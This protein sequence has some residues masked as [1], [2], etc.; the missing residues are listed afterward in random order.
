MATNTVAQNQPGGPG[1][2]TIS[3]A[4]R[5][6]YMQIANLTTNCIVR[7]KTFENLLSSLTSSIKSAYSNHKPLLS[8][9]SPSGPS[10]LQGN[11]KSTNNNTTN[12]NG[13]NA[14][15]HLSNIRLEIDPANLF[16][17]DFSMLEVEEDKESLE[18]RRSSGVTMDCFRKTWLN[19]P[20]KSSSSKSVKSLEN[21]TSGDN[22]NSVLAPIPGIP[23]FP[24]LGIAVGGNGGAGAASAKRWRRCAR[25]AAVMEDVISP[26]PA[27][28]WLVMQ[29][30]RCFCGGYWDTLVGGEMVA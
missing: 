25:C 30:R 11:E 10:R 13:G 18:T 24:G 3:A 15:G 20:P 16:F 9:N 5:A 22:S 4:L 6:A 29:Q 21:G 1:Q 2:Q 14:L 28:Q 17:A 26:R 23:G 27:L 12:T 8:G 7:I 19:N